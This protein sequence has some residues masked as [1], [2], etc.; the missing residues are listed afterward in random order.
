MAT[1][2]FDP[3]YAFALGAISSVTGTRSLSM[4]QS[5]Q[6]AVLNTYQLQERQLKRNV[7]S[8][9]AEYTV[10]SAVHRADSCRLRLWLQREPVLK[11]RRL[12]PT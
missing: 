1:L 12:T 4:R 10:Y 9:L 11:H 2:I 6:V 8:E 5:D 3:V 7:R